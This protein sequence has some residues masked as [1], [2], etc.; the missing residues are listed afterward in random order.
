MDEMTADD[1]RRLG[2]RLIEEQERRFNGLKNRAYNAAGV[3]S[4]TWE[5][6]INRRPMRDFKVRQI[7][8][9]LWPETEGDWRKIPGIEGADAEYLRLLVEVERA[10]FRPENR[11]AIEAAI[12]ADMRGEVVRLAKNERGMA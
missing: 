12:E 4:A 7:V 3:N 9:N 2:D 10:G 6:A 5:N 8:R 1:R 11:A